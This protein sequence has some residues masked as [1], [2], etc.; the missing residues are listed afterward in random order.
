MSPTS[1][2]AVYS[3]DA[4]LETLLDAGADPNLGDFY[5]VT[6]LMWAAGGANPK[7]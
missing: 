4:A 7:P 2:A 1:A 3:R 6:P 5:G